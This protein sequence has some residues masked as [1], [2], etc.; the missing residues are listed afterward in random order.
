[1]HR[2]SVTTLLTSVLLLVSC[3]KEPTAVT[4]SPAAQDTTPQD[5]GTLIRRLESDVRTL[6]PIL[7]ENK[8]DRY[9]AAYLFTPM[10]H[11]GADLLPVPGLAE[12]WEISPDGK[13]YT[14]H[15][16]PNATFSDRTPVR[17]ADVLFTL[18]KIADPQTEAAQIAGGFEQLDLKRTRVVDVKTIVVAF[19]EALAP[20]LIRFND[21]LVLP[22]HVY[23]KGDFK[24]DYNNIAVGSG[25][26]QLAGR[27]AGK[28][29]VVERR[30]DYWGRKP[31][32]GRVVFKVI[33][34][35]M[36]AWNALKRGDIDETA[37]GSEVWIREHTNPL[38][39]QK[40]DF[41]RFYTLNYNFIAWNGRSTI[42]NDKRVRRAMAMCI[43]L[44]SIIANLFHGTA[45]AMSGPFTPDQWAYNPKVPV[46]P[47]DPPGA[48]Q[49]L[50]S[51]GWRDTDGDGLLDRDGKPLRFDLLIY[52][53]TTS[54]IPFAQLL[55]A[56]LKKIGVQLDIAVV[57]WASLSH[58]VLAGQYQA[59]FMGWDLDA[60]PD[61]FGLFHSSQFPPRGQDLV[62]YASPEA[63]RL[64]EQ[65]RRELDFGKRVG[66]YHQLH[67]VLAED[68]PYAWTTQVSVKWG[69]S[70]RLRNVQESRG[71]GLFTWYPGEFDWWIPRD[72]RVHD[73]K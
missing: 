44:Q 39:Q 38:L 60:D 4:P 12:K 14:F 32:F 31:H 46:V 11:I 64:I 69:I 52:S 29:I 13:D 49:L 2:Q 19:R 58:R 6:N 8:Y 18:R 41:R 10:I 51:A 26:Y 23:G 24:N 55:Q 27:D 59:S 65:G 72:E 68:Q 56:E 5:G 15:L 42:F 33:I 43:D 48:R 54:G 70:K 21:L 50:E 71:F 66:I 35:D 20:Q 17:A 34:D 73:K 47:F 40:I 30:D 67:A 61:P 28:Q 37:I 3:A 9:V 62:F 45:R 36:T 1:V 57:D 53:G 63:N 25:P 22:E 7:S 16:H